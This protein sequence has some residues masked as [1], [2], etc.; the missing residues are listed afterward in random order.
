MKALKSL[1]QEYQNTKFKD[2]FIICVCCE[3]QENT[4][5]F[6]QQAKKEGF[7]LPGNSLPTK[8]CPANIFYIN[9]DGIIEI[10]SLPN[11]V[12]K[13]LASK[14]QNMVMVNYGEYIN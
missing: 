5:R 4:K 12:I 7:E 3:T 1:I 6:L 9:T 2:L 8:T 10:P 13:K 14:A 11:T